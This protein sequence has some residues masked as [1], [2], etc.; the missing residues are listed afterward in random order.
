M[1][2]VCVY[3]K[4]VCKVTGKG[5]QHARRLLSTI[6]I[7]L[8]KESHHFITKKEFCDYTGIDPD[9]MNLD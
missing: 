3:P 9:L 2:R 1:E 6:R 7:A 4:D 5:L 8:N